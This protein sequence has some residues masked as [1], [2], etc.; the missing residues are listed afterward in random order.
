M[1]IEQSCMSW[2]RFG[3]TNETVGSRAYCPPGK[4]ENGRLAAAG[5][6]V[7]LIH[8]TCLRAYPPLVHTPDPAAGR[9]SEYPANVRPALISSAARLP[10]LKRCGQ[11]SSVMP[12]VLP[13]NRAR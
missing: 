10:E 13:E 5:T 6:L 1:A 12:C 11:L 8:G 4:R 9:S 7:K 2:H 3:M